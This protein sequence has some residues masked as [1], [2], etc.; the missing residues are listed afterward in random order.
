MELIASLLTSFVYCPTRSTS[1]SIV[2]YLVNSPPRFL[3][4]KRCHCQTMEN[5]F[6]CLQIV[7]LLLQYGAKV[8]LRCEVKY[9]YQFHGTPLKMAAD[10]AC[11]PLVRVLLHAGANPDIPGKYQGRF[12]FLIHNR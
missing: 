5:V 12:K 4:I 1:V 7:E 3:I 8:N 9:W 6:V 11:T 2:D 10:R